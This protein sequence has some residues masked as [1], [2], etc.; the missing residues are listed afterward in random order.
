MKD[1]WFEIYKDKRT[2]TSACNAT[3]LSRMT[4]LRW[5]QD[6]P[7]FAEKVR[8]VKFEIVEALE[9]SGMNK[10]LKGRSDILTIFFLKSLYPEQYREMIK[11]EVD[12]RFVLDMTSQ[13]AAIIKKLVPNTCPSCKTHLGLTNQIAEELTKL[14][15]GITAK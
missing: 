10:A 1:A 2:I 14:S 15:E 4:I 11:H 7:D 13:V 9:S 3:K 8:S 6:D 12:H 5:C